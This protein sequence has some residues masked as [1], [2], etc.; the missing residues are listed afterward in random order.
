VAEVFSPLF[1]SFLSP[2]P[3]GLCCRFRAV[4]TAHFTWGEYHVDALFLFQFYLHSKFSPYL[5]EIGT[6]WPLS[7]CSVYQRFFFV[8]YLLLK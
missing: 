8:Q 4:K 3:L 6:W 5:L 7:F 2:C 1:W